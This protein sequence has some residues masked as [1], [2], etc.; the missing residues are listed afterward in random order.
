MIIQKLS[1]GWE[2]RQCK[3]EKSIPAQVPGSVYTDLL[4]NLEM[5]DPYWKDNEEQALL[6]MENDY[7]Y[8]ERFDCCQEVFSCPHVILHFDGLDTLAQIWP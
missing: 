8:E 5:E 1:Q 3:E 4:R 6:L 2:L 7:E